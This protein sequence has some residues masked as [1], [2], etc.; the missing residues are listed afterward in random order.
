[1]ARATGAPASRRRRKRF[2]KMAKGQRG[3]RSKLYRQARESV[4][5]GLSYAFRD[6]RAKKRLFRNLWIARINAACR[7]ND[8]S[9]N[10]F[11][12]GLKKAKISLDRKS[13]A[14]LALNDKKAFKQ[15]AELAKANI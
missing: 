6:R 1:M 14:D 4:Q 9:Y 10:K 13:I 5:K 7:A 8:L 2:L 3:A 12:N 11:M 15:L